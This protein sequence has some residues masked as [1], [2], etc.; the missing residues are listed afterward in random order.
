M[1]GLFFEQVLQRFVNNQTG[2]GSHLV[3]FQL[4]LVYQLDANVMMWESM[5]VV[6]ILMSE[7]LSE[8]LVHSVD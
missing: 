4:L 5:V 3:G 7:T 8:I 2:W 6:L 1:L